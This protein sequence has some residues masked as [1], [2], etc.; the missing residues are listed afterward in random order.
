M[1]RQVEVGIFIAPVEGIMDGA[2][3]RWNDILAMA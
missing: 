2:T 3:P 1:A